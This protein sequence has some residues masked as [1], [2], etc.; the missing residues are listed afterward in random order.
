[1]GHVIE[2][3]SDYERIQAK[4]WADYVFHNA[5][6]TE[7][8]FNPNI[9]L[10]EI[11]NRQEQKIEAR[12]RGDSLQAKETM[13]Y[14]ER[15]NVTTI[16][17]N[18]RPSFNQ[19]FEFALKGG[20]SDIEQAVS[21]KKMVN[22]IKFLEQKVYDRK[23][24]PDTFKE[25]V[26]RM[27]ILASMVTATKGLPEL[28]IDKITKKTT[29]NVNAYV[30]KMKNTNNPVIND[31]HKI[32]AYTKDEFE[33]IIDGVK[34]EKV[35]LAL[36]V[37]KS[38]AFRIENAETLFLNTKWKRIS[39]KDWVRE[40]T[41]ENKVAIVSKGNQRHTVKLPDKLFEELKKYA[42][43]NG[44]FHVHRSTIE[45][46]AKKSAERQGIK[47]ISV[48]NLRATTAYRLYNNLI[49]EGYT[50]KEA[51]KM[52]SQKLYH[53]RGDIT[54]YYLDSANTIS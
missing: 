17:H 30:E 9:S 45:K 29:D 48:H 47:F 21:G 39:E 27:R 28:N 40:H 38:T 15:T 52:V 10:S 24:T 44:V 20:A 34:N 7:K 3:L 18:L 50:D 37:I 12:N 33:R 6:Q 51:K 26:S 4:S 8:F 53:G 11:K 13:K 22:Y 1:M 41:D 32:H 14:F 46:Q 54:K 16:T 43:K 35:R 49:E 23:I 2:G 19:F 42:N 25:Y 31:K 5:P 36:R